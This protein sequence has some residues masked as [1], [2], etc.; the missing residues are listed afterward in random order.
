[1]KIGWRISLG[2]VALAGCKQTEEA[3]SAP[4]ASA[5]VSPEER[6]AAVRGGI[7]WLIRHQSEDGS[8]KAV[9]F[10]ARCQGEACPGEGV[11]ENLDVGVTSLALLAIRSSSEEFDEQS[12]RGLGWLVARQAEDGAI[13][14]P[15]GQFIYNHGAATMALA[16]Y[17]SKSQFARVRPA[18]ERAVAYLCR[19][20]TKARDGKLRGWRYLPGS[21]ESDTSVT[22]WAVAALQKAQGAGISIPPESLRGALAWIEE[23]TAKDYQVGYLSREDAGAQVKVP[24][25]NEDYENHPAMT[26]VGVYVRCAVGRSADRAV[27]EGARI[28]GEDLPAWDPD[29]WNNDYYYWHRGTLA[30]KEIGGESWER[31]KAALLSTLLP[32]RTGAGCAKGS[33]SAEDRWGAI[34]GRV[35]ATAMNVLSLQL[36]NG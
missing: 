36:A 30:M 27:A 6:A 33:W 26:A 2:I 18:L 14:Q 29:K 24:G 20:Q 35:Y 3:A 16:A 11:Y 34:G 1:M 15:V 22:S 28:L 25:I 19:S 31:W 17:A 12:D 8:W 5:A 32:S 9:R 7:D 10:T 21:G 23:V 4:A 13:G